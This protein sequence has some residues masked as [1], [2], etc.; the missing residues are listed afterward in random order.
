M[1]VTI[2]TDT[3]TSTCILNANET[4]LISGN[5]DVPAGTMVSVTIDGQSAA[6]QGAAAP[7]GS[8]P[9]RPAN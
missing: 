8:V 3:L 4:N 1:G 9:G 6:V 5:V 7:I 2:C